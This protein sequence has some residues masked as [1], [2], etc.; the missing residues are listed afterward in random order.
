MV[1]ATGHAGGL[2]WPSDDSR[3]NDSATRRRGY[4]REDRDPE[5]SRPSRA[6]PE[7]DA[8]VPRPRH[9]REVLCPDH[10]HGL[11]HLLLRAGARAHL[12]AGVGR[13]LR[14]PQ[15]AEADQRRD[16]IGARL[17]DRAC[18][19]HLRHQRRVADAVAP[20]RPPSRRRR[21][22]PAEPALREVQG[23]GHDAADDDRRGRR[24]PARA[25]RGHRSTVRWACTASSSRPACRARTRGSSSRTPPARTSS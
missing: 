4:P 9:R 1:N 5:E 17:D 25:L 20:A 7:G 6:R 15:D 23:R 24:G 8:A 13:R 12:P 18:R 14:S 21:V 22:R 11:P 10:L 19:L 16:R 3:A 2:D